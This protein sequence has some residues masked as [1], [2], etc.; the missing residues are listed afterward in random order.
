TV[1]V[2]G[3]GGGREL[4]EALRADASSVLAVDINPTILKW[5]RGVDRK[6]NNDL[7]YDPRVTLRLGEGRHVV[8]SAGRRFDVIVIHA[9]DTYAAAAAGA[10]ALTENFLYTKE[11]MK[12]YLAALNPGGVMSIQRWLFNPP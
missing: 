2:I 11:A 10:Y 7:F 9:I 6:L 5:V 3:V 12:D 1:A 4:A 8:R